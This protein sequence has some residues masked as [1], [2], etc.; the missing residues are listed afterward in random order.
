MARRTI[1][2]VLAPLT[3]AAGCGGAAASGPGSSGATASAPFCR[4]VNSMDAPR[5]GPQTIRWA[6][7]DGPGQ[8]LAGAIRKS[9]VRKVRTE[10]AAWDPAL[11][12]P[13]TAESSG[14]LP[15]A[16]RNQEAIA[17]VAYPPPMARTCL[18]LGDGPAKT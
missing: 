4:L 16:Q 14:Q 3:V 9:P 2:L 13:E 15:A 6:T 17:L 11:A 10:L 8:E 7:G 12:R 1:L 18:Q 5:T